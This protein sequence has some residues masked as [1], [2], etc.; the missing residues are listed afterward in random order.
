MRRRCPPE[1]SGGIW[2]YAGLLEAM[3]NPEHPEHATMLEWLGGPIDPEAFD[4][5]AINRRLGASR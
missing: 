2:G 1:D 5:G 4:L 3:G